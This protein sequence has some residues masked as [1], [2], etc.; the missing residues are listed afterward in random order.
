MRRHRSQRSNEH[1][2]GIGS[3]KRACLRHD[4]GRGRLTPP[5]SIDFP[6]PPLALTRTVAAPSRGCGQP[7]CPTDDPVQPMDRD[8]ALREGKPTITGARSD[9]VRVDSISVLKCGTLSALN[10]QPRVGICRD[11]WRVH[12]PPVAILAV[13]Y[14]GKQKQSPEAKL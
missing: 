13:L 8:F 1:W 6:H 14:S 10:D 2:R 4:N 12:E 5:R 11:Q 3:L 9:Q 7:R